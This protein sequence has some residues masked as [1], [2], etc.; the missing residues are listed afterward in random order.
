MTIN[1]TTRT[2]DALQPRHTPYR[3][4]DAGPVPGL[5]LQISPTGN[6]TWVLSYRED[7]RRLFKKLGRHPA[8]N[9]E[10][11]RE[12]ATR[13]IRE[14]AT[15]TRQTSDATLKQMLEAYLVNLA[16]KKVR[17]STIDAVR[18]MFVL[19]VYGPLGYRYASTLTPADI[20]VPLRA[21]VTRG[22]PMAAL[23]LR[24]YLR[25]AFTW[26][27]RSEHALDREPG[28]HFGIV[29]NPVEA[30]P[31]PAKTTP[32]ERFP[33]MEELAATYIHGNRRGGHS[34]IGAL[35]FHICMAG[36]RVE[37]SI[38]VRWDH[39][40]EHNGRLWLYIDRT[41]TGR[42]H[43]VPLPRI[44]EEVV[45]QQRRVVRWADVMFP[46]QNSLQS[47]IAYTSLARHLAIL[48]FK[49]PTIGVWSPREVR[50]AAKSLLVDAGVPRSA[51][52]R[53]HQHSDGSV[54]TRH[55]DRS[56]GEL[57]L[58]Q[59]ADTWDTLLRAA[60]HEKGISG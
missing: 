7:T 23:H 47:P 5:H 36:L 18:R 1:L 37:E 52:D 40:R 8:V 30:I 42:P 22:S 3:V 44:A 49:E 11:A 55:Y 12:V 60:I 54:A 41:K 50:R 27:M 2:I 19:N 25:A 21:V 58:L 9:R 33:T 53:W 46:A 16:A 48:R 45:T 17:P 38:N 6:K 28:L 24:T 32:G 51:V 35:R 39:L 13:L 4:Y 29:S 26:A 31:V 10:V 15:G 20:A 57:E 34:T 43:A 56:K 59:V 14:R